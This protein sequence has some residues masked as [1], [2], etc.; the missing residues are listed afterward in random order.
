[1]KQ[2]A[3]WAPLAW[4]MGGGLLTTLAGVVIAALVLTKRDVPASA[5]APIA[6]G[7]LSLGA[8]VAGF[9]AA[10]L[11]GAQGLVAGALTGG[12]LWL[13]TALVA[14]FVSGPAFTLATPVRLALSVTLGG[15]AGVLGVNL[16]ARRRLP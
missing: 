7:C 11:R 6:T 15:V 3:W 10:R 1:M 8:A 12:A 14:L 13:V 16:A 5:A 4:G 9:V 2:S